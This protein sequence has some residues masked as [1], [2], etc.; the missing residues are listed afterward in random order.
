MGRYPQLPIAEI[1]PACTRVS[2][3][4][5][6]EAYWSKQPR[7]EASAFDEIRAFLVDGSLVRR[8]TTQ[9]IVT[10]IAKK[11]I[12]LLNASAA[13]TYLDD[14]KSAPPV[15][16][17]V[18]DGFADRPDAAHRMEMANSRIISTKLADAA[19]ATSPPTAVVV[20]DTTLSTPNTIPDID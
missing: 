13:I 12:N 17:V 7:G 10:W 11:Y 4:S 19:A 15:K 16:V 6:A 8:A 18:W 2:A 1:L 14:S 5:V 20:G 9:S 3:C